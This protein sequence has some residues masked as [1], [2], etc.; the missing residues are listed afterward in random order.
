MNKEVLKQVIYDQ[1]NSVNKKKKRVVRKLSETLISNDEILIIS[2]VRRCGKSTLLQQI[3]EKQI[4]KDFYLN[5]D[6]ERLIHFTVDDFQILYELFSELFGEQHTFYFDEIQNVVGW[7]R[8]V[9]RIYDAGNKVFVTGSNANMLSRELG[10][11]L[12]GRYCRHVLYPFSFQESLDFFDITYDTSDLYITENKVRIKRKFTNYLLSGGFPAYLKENSDNYIHSLFENIIY[13]DVIVRNKLTHEREI[14]ELVHFLASN[15]ATLSS[16]NSLTKVIDVKNPTTVKNY[17]DFMQDCYFLFQINKYDVSLK[18][19]LH[20]PKKIYFIDNIILRKIGFSFS[21]NTGR[22]LE[23]VVFIELKRREKDVYYH[24]EKNECDFVL[25]RGTHIT[26]AIQVCHVFENEATKQREITG[27]LD[28]LDCYNLKEGLI[29]TSD[30]EEEL[31]INQKQIRI[32]PVWKWL[33][34]PSEK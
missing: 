27:L 12:T 30:T 24:Y 14:K 6:D 10:T 13:K 7:E 3:R 18:K 28:A 16:Y 9:R 22:L 26:E 1:R 8:F 33:L 19:Q 34:L 20:N 4:D 32:M 21:D 15:P 2:G 29:L 25:R 17:I 31:T 5:F 23:N 11:R